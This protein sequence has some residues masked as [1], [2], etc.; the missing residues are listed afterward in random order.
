MHATVPHALQHAHLLYESCRYESSSIVLI[1]YDIHT[2]IT[3]FSRLNRDVSPRQDPSTYAQ[4]LG[5]IPGS[6]E[7]LIC[8]MFRQSC[9]PRIAED[10]RIFLLM[11]INGVATLQSAHTWYGRLKV[12][13]RTKHRRVR[14]CPRPRCGL[15]MPVPALSPT[16]NVD[17]SPGSR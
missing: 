10:V 11:D 12:H 4:D 15:V 1:L 3:I 7:S 13:V 14:D 5:Y 17:N 2:N 8:L 6:P 16:G 9:S